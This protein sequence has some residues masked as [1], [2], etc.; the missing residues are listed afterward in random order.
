MPAL[1]HGRVING[2]NLLSRTITYGQQKCDKDRKEGESCQQKEL[3]C[4]KS[5]QPSGLK[6]RNS[7]VTRVSSKPSNQKWASTALTGRSFAAKRAIARRVGQQ[8]RIKVEGLPDNYE[9]VGDKLL[10]VLF[11]WIAHRYKIGSS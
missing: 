10:N 4:G 8:R 2:F 6:P 7:L 9:I 1:T 3:C 11:L 5:L